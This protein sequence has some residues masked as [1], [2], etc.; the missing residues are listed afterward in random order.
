MEFSRKNLGQWGLLL[1]LVI[2]VFFY[3]SFKQGETEAPSPRALAGY[4]EEMQDLWYRIPPYPGS[5]APVPLVDA[6]PERIIWERLQPSQASYE[7][8][9]AFYDQELIWVGWQAIGETRN[10][11]GFTGPLYLYRRDKYHLLLNKEP[12]GILLRMTWSADLDLQ[13]DAR[14]RP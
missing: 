2:G 6:T 9:R 13:V 1:L 8:I 12:E 7:E 5:K 10:L 11:P 3:R 14:V 4:Q